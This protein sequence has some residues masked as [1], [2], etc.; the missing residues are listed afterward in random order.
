MP[1]VAIALAFLLLAGST[2]RA[3][4]PELEQCRKLFA[5]PTFDCGCVAGFMK[6]R[7]NPI[8]R[9]IILTFWG[10]NVDRRRYQD[11]DLDSLYEHHGSRS[12][13]EA[14]YRFNLV[15]VQLFTECPGTAPD[16]DYGY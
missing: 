10:A 16:A 3:E 14:L 7:F 6:P 9:K 5:S 11:S 8:E 13:T 15:R 2:C 1:R 4:T 12:I